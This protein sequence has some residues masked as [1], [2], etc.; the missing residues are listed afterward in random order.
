MAGAVF[1]TVDV[2][3]FAGDAF[4]GVVFGVDGEAFFAGAACLTGA[5][6]FAGAA[7]ADAAFGCALLAVEVTRMG[8]ATDFFTAFVAVFVLAAAD[9]GAAFGLAEAETEA[10]P[11]RALAAGFAVL[12][13]AAVFFFAEAVAI[14]L[15]G[16][17]FFVA[18]LIFGGT[19]LRMPPHNIDTSI[20][21]SG[22]FCI[23]ACIRLNAP[24][25]LAL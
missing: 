13:A 21:Q 3:F 16:A 11:A 4:F 20:A 14:R 17:A 7:L 2:V 6:F 9:F 19:M 8:A 1:F 23:V 25:P 18:T 22:Q 12:E 24:A 15:A 10:E 5:A